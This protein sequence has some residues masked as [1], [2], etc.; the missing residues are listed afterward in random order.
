MCQRGVQS[1]LRTTAPNAENLQPM[2][3]S[4]FLFRETGI[5]NQGT[6]GG[7]SIELKAVE[8]P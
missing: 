4:H 2:C 3:T 1:I 8:H 6:K 5:E 7:V